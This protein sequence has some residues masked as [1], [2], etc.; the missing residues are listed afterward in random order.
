MRAL[1]LTLFSFLLFS[2]SC[3]RSTIDDRYEALLSSR[4]EQ[5]GY[6][7]DSLI[8][9]CEKAMIE[10]K[11]FTNNSSQQYINYIKHVNKVGDVVAYDFHI[12]Q[13]TKEALVNLD[14]SFNADNYTEIQEGEVKDTKSIAYKA[15]HIMDELSTQGDISPTT[16]TASVLKHITVDDFDASLY[17]LLFF[18]FFTGLTDTD[19]GLR[20]E[21]P[22]YP[23]EE[24]KQVI[25]VNPN[26]VLEIYITGSDSIFINRQPMELTGIT[27]VVKSFLTGS[28]QDSSQRPFSMS[29]KIVSLKNERGTKVQLYMDVYN[30]LTRAYME[31]RNELSQEQ[32]GKDFKDL[33]NSEKKVIQTLCPMRISEAE[34][35]GD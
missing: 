27:E 8:D 11:Y 21:L 26:Q 16:I 4:L 24:T 34:P 9:V 7:M 14:V 20:V 13:L 25:P 1:T 22:N 33:V 3:Y 12:G 35:I 2:T 10:G 30:E 31:V 5:A 18:K 15:V 17:R 28:S 32:Y 23:D 29:E 6:N 19:R